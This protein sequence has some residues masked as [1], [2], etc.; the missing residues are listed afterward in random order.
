V[1]I[2]LFRY[3]LRLRSYGRISVE[4]RRFLSNRG[5]LTQNFTWKRSPSPTILF[6]RKLG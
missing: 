2:K 1:L 5:R 6:L 3:V 4:N